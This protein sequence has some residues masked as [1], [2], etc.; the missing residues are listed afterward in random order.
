MCLYMYIC[1]FITKM[2]SF[3]IQKY[4]SCYKT[5]FSTQG[6]PFMPVHRELLIQKMIF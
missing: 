6:H 4:R 5:W 1:M 3:H 2:E